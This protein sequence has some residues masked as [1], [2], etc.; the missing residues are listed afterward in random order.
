MKTKSKSRWKKFLDKIAEQNKETYGEG[1]LNCCE[2][3][4]VIQSKQPHS[5]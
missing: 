2:L 3:K 1:G 5:N 4:D